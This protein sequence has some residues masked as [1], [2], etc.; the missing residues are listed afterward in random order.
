M[1]GRWTVAYA[2][3]V[4]GLPANASIDMV[5][6]S[7]RQ[8]CKKYHPDDNQDEYALEAYLLIQAAYEFLCA[9]YGSRDPFFTA[10]SPKTGTS[11][12]TGYHN[13]M[14][15]DHGMP[16]GYTGS[17]GNAS[18]GNVSYRNVSGGNVRRSKII[19][20]GSNPEREKRFEQIK[21]GNE[22]KEERERR[23]R[24]TEKK[25]AEASAKTRT[26][27]KSAH[28]TQIEKERRRREIES[29]YYRLMEVLQM[30]NQEAE[31]EKQD[32]AV[33]ARKKAFDAFRKYE[34]RKE[35]L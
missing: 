34:E 3:Q 17:Q 18:Y 5:K 21:R 13:G 28:D 33:Y 23:R 30:M 26:F 6:K 31:Q 9:N 20:T 19:G 29:Q 16:N 10:E 11:Q 12:Y 14:N 22:Q 32:N 15:S 4:L 1:Q 8:L 2:L 27:S 35:E 25:A 7:Y 24:E